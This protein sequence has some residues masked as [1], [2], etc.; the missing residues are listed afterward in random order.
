MPDNFLHSRLP[1]REAS[2]QLLVVVDDDLGLP[3]GHW[4][5]LHRAC[6]ATTNDVVDLSPTYGVADDVGVRSTPRRNPWLGHE[7]TQFRILQHHMTR[8]QDP[9]R[10]VSRVDR[11]KPMAQNLLACS[12]LY[13]Y[14]ATGQ[15]EL[16]V[17]CVLW[18]SPTVRYEYYISLDRLA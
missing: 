7:I 11:C 6:G 13:S 15:P 3:I 17:M 10:Y 9:V 8:N 12:A 18:S 4:R 14:N 2:D 5:I 1:A 16:T